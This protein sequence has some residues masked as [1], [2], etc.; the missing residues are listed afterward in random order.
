MTLGGSVI[1][2]VS[3]GR[4]DLVAA[5]GETT[6]ESA[7]RSIHRRMLAHPVGRDILTKR[8]RITEDNIDPEQM[9]LRLPEGSFGRDYAEFMCRH[10]FQAADRAEVQFVDDP[11][12]AYVMQ[13]YREVH[14]FWHVLCDIPPTVR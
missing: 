9:L 6:G 3:P 1:S 4:A 14:D 2:L 8:P 5:V 13:R 10:G 7:L 12:L 11:D